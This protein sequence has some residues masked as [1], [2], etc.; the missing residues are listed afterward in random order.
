LLSHKYP[1]ERIDEA[2]RQSEWH[3]K[4]TTGITRAALVP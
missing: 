2:F 1:L 4:D 3:A